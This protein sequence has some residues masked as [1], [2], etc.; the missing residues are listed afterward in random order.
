MKT[1]IMIDIGGTKI[2]AAVFPARGIT[3]LHV[4]RIRTQCENQSSLE[5]LIELIHRIWPKK[6]RVVAIVIAVPGLLDLNKGMVLSAVNIPGWINLPLKQIIEGKFKTP[7]YLGNDA[8]FAAYGEWRHGAGK[9]HHNL[10]FLTISTG[11]GGGIIINDRLLTGSRGFATELGHVT[12][13]PK[14]PICSCGHRGHL[15]ALASG[16]AISK[17]VQKKLTRGGKST[18]NAFHPPTA[19]QIATAAQQGDLLAKKAF[20]RAGKFLGIAIANYLHIFNPTCVILG[21]GV[22]LS[23]D[24]LF[25]PLNRSLAQ[26]ILNPEYL[27]KVVITPAK[28][29]DDAGLIGALEYVR[30]FSKT[31]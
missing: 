12:I 1:Y 4:K 10:I 21:G 7:T 9:G 19:K 11:I 3:A 13:Q 6:H 2:R 30:D 25:K 26:N 14:G 22:S 29:K 8:S 23:G 15:E 17:Y 24:I 31:K 5:R 27:H 18:L 20:N 28:L 16:T